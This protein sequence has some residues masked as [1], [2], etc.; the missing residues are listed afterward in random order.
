MSVREREREREGVRQYMKSGQAVET[1][2][3]WSSRGQDD[4]LSYYRSCLF[5]KTPPPRTF[6]PIFRSDI[7]LFTIHGSKI[8]QRPGATYCYESERWEI[9]LTERREREEIC[10]DRD[11]GH[12]PTN[13]WRSE[14]TMHVKP[15]KQ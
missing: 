12:E 7:I 9:D 14:K 3:C 10:A 8:H 1:E 5:W 2:A 4:K 15:E 6:S 11:L 13:A